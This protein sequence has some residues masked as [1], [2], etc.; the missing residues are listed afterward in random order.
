MIKGSGRSIES[1]NM[2]EA[3]YEVKDIFEKFGGHH[4][5]AGMSLKKDRLDEFRKKLNKNS[6]LTKE[7]FI[8][9]IWIDIA[10]PFS[11]LSIDFVRE[12]EK[13]EP[14]GNK[15]DEPKFARKD[16]KILSKN[17]LGKNKNVVKMV[18][19][20][21]DGT[22]MDGIYFGDGEAFFEELKDKKEIDI[23]YYPDINEYGG[24]E[25]LQ[26]IITGYKIKI[27]SK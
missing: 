12:L 24:R 3:L 14:Y 16:I 27:Y 2:F 21:V 26:V 25:S 11:Y 19:E 8:Q 5:A 20:D 7:D 10:L 15:N 13:L 23:I 22:R 17:I 6:K 4:M 1:Y 9:K 18:L